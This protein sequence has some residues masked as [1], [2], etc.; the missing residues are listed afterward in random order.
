MHK[1]TRNEVA[2]SNEA[3]QIIGWKPSKDPKADELRN[4]NLNQTESKVNSGN[5]TM[6]DEGTSTGESEQDRIVNELL[7]SLESEIEKIIGDYI[8]DNEEEEE[9]S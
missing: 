9:D 6:G 7:D 8:S 2:T 5:P 1:L 4:K 3:R